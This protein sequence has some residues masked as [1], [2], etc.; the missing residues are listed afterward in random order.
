MPEALKSFWHS[1]RAREGEH[2][3]VSLRIL[4]SALLFLY[5][6]YEHQWGWHTP[7]PLNVVVFSGFYLLVSLFLLVIL[8]NRKAGSRRRQWLSMFSDISAIS[9]VMLYLQDV[10]VLLFWMYLWVIVGNGIRYGVR[11]LMTGY[12]LSLVGFLSVLLLNPFWS[13]QP[14][15]AIGLFLTLM[16]IPLYLLKLLKQLNQ[17]MH[18]AQEG[19]QAKSRF[20]AHMSHEMRTPLNGVMGTSDLL[21]TTPLDPEQ[22]DLVNTLRLSA[23]TLLQLIEDVLDFSRIESGKLVSEAVDFDLHYLIRST[24]DMFKS[25]TRAKGLRL[26]SRFSAATP[27]LLHGDV[28]HLRQILVNLLGNAIKFTDQGSV[29]IRITP[30]QQTLHEALLRFEVI[31]TGIGIPESALETIFD[32]FTQANSS[33]SRLYGG[34]G[35]GTTIARQL[36]RLLGGDMGV[37]SRVGVGTTFWFEVPLQLQHPSTTTSPSTA[38]SPSPLGAIHVLTLGLKHEE[39]ATVAQWLHG[40]AVSFQH[41]LSLTHFFDALKYRSDQFHRTTVL[42]CNPCNVGLEAAAFVQRVHSGAGAGLPL[43]I[44]TPEPSSAESALLALGY[45]AVLPIPL[46]KTLLF[47]I[48]HSIGAPPPPQGVLS[49]RDHYAR[50]AAEKTGTSI[51]LAEDNATSRKIIAKILEHAGHQVDLV[52][53]GEEALDR[54]EAHRYGLIILDMN[55]PLMGGLDVL[56]IHRAT[57][58]E[59]PPTPVIIFTANATKEAMRDAEAAGADLYLSKPIEAMALLD[60]VQKLVAARPV[61]PAWSTRSTASTTAPSPP[62]VPGPSSTPGVPLLQRSTVHHL[63]QLGQ[64]QKDFMPMVIQGFLSET[65]RLLKAMHS[66][67]QRQDLGAL[68]DLAH[69]IKGSSGNLGAQ[70]LHDC[71]RAWML[72]ERGQLSQQGA[73]LLQQTLSCFQDTQ[74]ALLDY[75]AAMAQDDPRQSGS[76]P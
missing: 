76:L 24:L 47:T 31:D 53:D 38:T 70:R 3:Q 34:S 35:L 50:Q 60:A 4:Y 54:L 22:Q 41:E 49:F 27:Y 33:I 73:V 28:L 44:V 20:L 75:L 18:L 46:D 17:A 25:Q 9:Y 8:L 11:A 1:V 61:Q 40:W 48:L 29:E 14:A 57:V 56:R 43:V 12:L 55:M 62:S 67:L 71:A 2:E 13:T 10:G 72:L 30:A 23:R 42:L 68:K 51:L 15:L 39:R 64:D 74:G 37:S 6:L 59:Q 45:A 26:E 36:A 58:R 32:S 19:S 21:L 52:E 63:E 7:I 16:L 5:A 65:E 66:A 69:T